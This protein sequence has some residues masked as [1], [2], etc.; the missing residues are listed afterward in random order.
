MLYIE[1]ERLSA[2]N[3][4]M[5]W[6][7]ACA[8]FAHAAVAFFLK[9]IYRNITHWI[10]S[11]WDFVRFRCFIGGKIA[12][13]FTK[14]LILGA[15]FFFGVAGSIFAQSDFFQKLSGAA[16]DLTKSKVQYDPNYYVIGYPNG[17]VPKNKGVCTDVIVRA[18][19]SM[20]VDLQKEVH[21]D[22]RAHFSLY[23]K[24][25]GLSAPDR[26][27]DHRRV[28]NLMTYFSRFGE[29]KSIAKNP[30]DY[31]PGDIVCWDLGNGVKHIG[32]VVEQ[33]S[34][35]EKRHCIVHNIG[36]GQ[37]VEDCLFSFEI[38]GHYRYQK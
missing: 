20:G 7:L 31:A 29:T 10:G 28:P 18:Y 32:L 6:Y 22:M 11:M 27:I 34:N 19:R 25:W 3:K 13:V 33:K 8:R 4:L 1:T 37:V 38:I 2:F 5:F 12:G 21:E 16:M 14:K 24:N 9:N 23:P 36:S 15:F 17:D 35:D 26:N 30:D